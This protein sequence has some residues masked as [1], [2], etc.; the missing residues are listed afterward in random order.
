MAKQ[1]FCGTGRRK[2]AIAQVRIAK[3][4]GKFSL[5]KG[6]K[7]SIEIFDQG[8]LYPLELVGEKRID[9]TAI[10]GGGGIESQK[11]ALRLGIARAL[12]RYNKEFEKTLKKHGLLTRDPREKERK[13][14]GLKG[15]RRAPQWQKR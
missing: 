12:C 7:Y 3:G 1:Y 5:V 10:L 9:I 8:A 14:P 13:K 6:G 2:N 4:S 11:Q 15:A